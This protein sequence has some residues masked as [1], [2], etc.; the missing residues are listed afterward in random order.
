V[1]AGWSTVVHLPSSCSDHRLSRY[2]DIP[3]SYDLH[4]YNWTSGNGYRTAGT[5]TTFHPTDEMCG[6]S[7]I[8][9]LDGRGGH[10]SHSQ[11][12]NGDHQPPHSSKS[13]IIS[14][15][16]LEMN[17]DSHDP[18]RSKIVQELDQSLD[19]IKHR[20]PDSRGYW[21]SADNRVGTLVNTLSSSISHT[22]T[23]KPPSTRART[24]K[25]QRPLPR[26]R[27]ALPLS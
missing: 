9:A 14:K 7:C 26:R 10:A 12:T 25:H 18:I 19:K 20:G 6:I 15:D 11:H 2:P 16:H 5:N 21:L 13:T 22:A 23:D 3:T 24:P 1:R 4:T 8:L 17:G 27:A